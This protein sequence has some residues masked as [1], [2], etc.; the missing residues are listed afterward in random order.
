[1]SSS[2]AAISLR[3]P[4]RE[5]AV[6]R[7]SSQRRRHSSTR[8]RAWRMRS[9]AFSTGAMRSGFS[10]PPSG[11][12]MSSAAGAPFFTWSASASSVSHRAGNHAE[13]RLQFAA[14]L[15][16][17]LADLLFVLGLEELPLA[18]VFEIH[19]DQI[20]VFPRRGDRGGHFLF[21]F[22]FVFAVPLSPQGAIVF[23]VQVLILERLGIVLGDELARRQDHCLIRFVAG[24]EPE[25]VG[26]LT[27]VEHVCVA[28]GL[29]PVDQR[30][31][32]LA[33]AA[34]P[35][36]RLWR[37]CGDVPVFGAY[38]RVLQVGC[39]G[40]VI[41][42]PPDRWKAAP[43]VARVPRRNDVPQTLISPQRRLLSLAQS[44]SKSAG[45]DHQHVSSSE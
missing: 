29:R 35:A 15:L 38:C 24:L 1:M 5:P 18:D 12:R 17:A 2:A 30:V 10:S 44:I 23:V 20:E 4:A 6:D 43:A 28:I 19:A 32:V 39:L 26:A 41:C 9:K 36:H 11:R 14:G 37:A 45:A 40:N 7:L 21:G 31:V 34:A 3:Y 33:R 25:F 13:R 8:C 27:P 42:S 22:S 16:D